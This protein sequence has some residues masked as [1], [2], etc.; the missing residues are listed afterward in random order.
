MF[1][2]LKQIKDLRTKAKSIQSTLAE[3]V[4]ENETKGISITMDGNQQVQTIHVNDSL[5][6]DKT[7]LEAAM[8]EAMNDTVKKVQK[9][10][11]KKLQD[12]GGLD[13]PG[14]S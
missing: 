3:E 6:S 13:L 12:M 9:A 1:N 14:L 8:V 11:A 7:R 4:I 10:M 5:M 2:K